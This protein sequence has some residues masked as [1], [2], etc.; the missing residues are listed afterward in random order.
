MFYMGIK[1]LTDSQDESDIDLGID[2]DKIDDEPD[3]SNVD[4]E[5]FTD[6]VDDENNQE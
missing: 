2:T 1:Q 6:E 5:M 4:S 3:E